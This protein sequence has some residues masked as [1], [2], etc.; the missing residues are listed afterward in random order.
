V[1]VIDGFISTAAAALAVA[2][3]PATQG[4]LVAGHQSEEP[5]HKLLLNHLRLTP[6]LSLNMRLGEGTGAVLAL[7]MLESAIALYTK[8]ATFDS[9]GVSGASS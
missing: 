4:Y 8:M 6:V 3:S 2:I 7:P 1:V 5:G 9:A